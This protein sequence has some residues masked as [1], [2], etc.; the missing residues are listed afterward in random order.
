MTM[1]YSIVILVAFIV[2]VFGAVL[3]ANRENP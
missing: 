2:F 3:Y 1:E